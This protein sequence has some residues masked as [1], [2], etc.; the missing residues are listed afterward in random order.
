MV[1]DDTLNVVQSK[2][3]IP[4]K[5][6]AQLWGSTERGAR[7]P[8]ARHSVQDVADVGVALADSDGVAA[9]TLA[10]VAARLG[11]TTSALYGHVDTK[12]VL[13]ELIVDRA[14]GPPPRLPASGTGPWQDRAR[15]WALALAERYGR[16]PWLGAVVVGGVPRRPS[17]YAWLDAFLGALEDAPAELDRLRLAQLLDGVVRARAAV[18]SDLAPPP[19]WLVTAV[20]GRFPRLAGELDRDWAT[21]DDELHYALDVVLRGCA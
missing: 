13:I 2:S 7:G 10:K 15:A 4:P 16:H 1:K 18:L 20:A 14:I 12:D 19:G 21:P 17:L 6:L 9:V 5:G 11:L 8:A 3:G